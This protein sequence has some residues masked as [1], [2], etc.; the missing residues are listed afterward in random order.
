ML[1]GCIYT[2]AG[3]DCTSVSKL[4]NGA[5][6]SDVPK[7]KLA[8]ARLRL[9][10]QTTSYRTC[11]SPSASKERFEPLGPLGSGLRFGGKNRTK[12]FGV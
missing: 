7:Q 12:R 3:I 9:A 1:L 5:L 4:Y 2:I 10:T 11:P 8:D 6:Y